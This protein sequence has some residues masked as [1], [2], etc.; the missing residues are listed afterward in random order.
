MQGN[1]P[2]VWITS[3]E[4]KAIFTSVPADPAISIIKQHYNR[5]HNYIAGPYNTSPHCW[6]SVWKIPITSSKVKFYEQVHGEAM[7]SP[8]SPTVANL[9]MES[10]SKAIHTSTAPNTPWLWLRYV[11][12]TFVIKQVQHREHIL[13]HINSIDPHIPFTTE[14]PSS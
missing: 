9:F 4:V 3:Y 12:D 5:T 11:D 10:E 6:N 14:V 8:I 2:V 1:L 13:H 7:G